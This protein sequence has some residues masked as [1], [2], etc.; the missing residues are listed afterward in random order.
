MVNIQV[1]PL[2]TEVRCSLSAVVK[3][4]AWLSTGKE[5]G[6]MAYKIG[7]DCISCGAC[8]EG[9]PADA[10]HE[11]KDHYEIDADACLE[12]GACEATCPNGAIK[13]E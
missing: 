13:A 4:K 1:T 8:A 11:G 9:C 2:Q 5:A 10:I 7:E 12:C 6:T 3:Q